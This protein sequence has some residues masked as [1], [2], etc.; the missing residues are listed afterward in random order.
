VLPAIVIAFGIVLMI[1]GMTARRDLDT[2]S[3]RTPG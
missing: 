2:T 3:D 1:R